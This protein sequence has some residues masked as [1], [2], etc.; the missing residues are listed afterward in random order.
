MQMDQQGVIDKVAEVEVRCSK[1]EFLETKK[2]NLEHS[3]PKNKRRPSL[4]YISRD[5]SE[6]SL[7][8]RAPSPFISINPLDENII[9]QSS[10]NLHSTYSNV[11]NSDDDN[12]SESFQFSK[13]SKLGA[14]KN[15]DVNYSDNYHNATER[16]SKYD[17]NDYDSDNDNMNFNGVRVADSATLASPAEYED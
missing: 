4:E 6:K 8:S 16:M 7:A 2:T 17:F 11:G 1:L 10:G 3:I 15:S 14:A 5:N 13:I 12:R 9:D